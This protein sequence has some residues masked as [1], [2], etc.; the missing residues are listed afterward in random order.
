M[1]IIMF[2]E[3]AEALDLGNIVKNAFDV[4]V[5]VTLVGDG[6]A[7]IEI[8]CYTLLDKCYVENLLKCL[9]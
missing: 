1:P 2:K 9:L 3:I 5:T 7:Q 4:S 6:M 8:Q